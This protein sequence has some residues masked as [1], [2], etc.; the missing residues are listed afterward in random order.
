MPSEI[1]FSYFI[2]N[3]HESGSGSLR[4]SSKYSI[5]LKKDFLEKKYIYKSHSVLE[6]TY[7]SA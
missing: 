4:E 7:N 2:E 6:I 1:Q 5:V 3:K